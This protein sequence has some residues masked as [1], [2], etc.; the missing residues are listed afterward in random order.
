[1]S[2]ELIRRPARYTGNAIRAT[3][4]RGESYLEPA[5]PIGHVICIAC[6]RNVPI[7][8]IDIH[9]R[10]HE[11]QRD[12]RVPKCERACCLELEAGEQVAEPKQLQ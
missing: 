11:A 5:Q 4:V 10:S 1:M 2:N 12:G 9:H 8:E 3:T 6:G 7:N